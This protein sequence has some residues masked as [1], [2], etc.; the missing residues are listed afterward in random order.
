[1]K[2]IVNKQT[3]SK[4]TNHKCYERIINVKK[5]GCRGGRG[6]GGGGNYFI[7]NRIE[8]AELLGPIIK[9]LLIGIK[10]HIFVSHF[11]PTDLDS[12]KEIP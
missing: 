6:P 2:K 4:R 5:T 9:I 12:I 7:F 8:S 10:L 1:M 3:T 11:N